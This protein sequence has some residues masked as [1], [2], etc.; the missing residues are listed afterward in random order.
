LEKKPAV[1]FAYPNLLPLK[2]AHFSLLRSGASRY[3]ESFAELNS[4][5]T[6]VLNVPEAEHRKDR[7]SG[8]NGRGGNRYRFGPDPIRYSFCHRIK[9]E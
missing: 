3:I 1:R 4:K 7:E 2:I 6:E 8:R 5:K 9:I